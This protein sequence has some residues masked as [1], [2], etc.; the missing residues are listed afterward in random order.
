MNRSEVGLNLWYDCGFINTYED[1]AAEHPEALACDS[2]PESGANLHDN[3]DLTP[4]PIII[5]TGIFSDVD[6]IGAVA[7]AN[8]LHSYGKGDLRAIVINTPSENGLSERLTTAAIFE[9]E[10]ITARE[11][12]D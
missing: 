10:F 2:L 3:T 9:S 1:H 8:T 5:D 12:L 7:V 11:R 6:D 4:K